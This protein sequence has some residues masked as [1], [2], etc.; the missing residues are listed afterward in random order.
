MSLL[1]RNLVMLIPLLLMMHVVA[2][3]IEQLAK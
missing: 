2:M 3:F 1:V